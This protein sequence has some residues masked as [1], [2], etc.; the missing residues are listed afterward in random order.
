[1][2]EKQATRIHGDVPDDAETFL[3]Q[4]NCLGSLGIEGRDY[5]VRRELSN[6]FIMVAA[7]PKARERV[8]SRSGDSD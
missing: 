7:L 4:P 8:V 1:M 3:T 5:W 6:G 2:R